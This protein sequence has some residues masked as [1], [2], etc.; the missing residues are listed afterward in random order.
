MSE[1]VRTSDKMMALLC[2]A[3][4]RAREAEE[5]QRA[6]TSDKKMALLGWEF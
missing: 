1:R 4:L 2:R 3:V 5:I 6:C